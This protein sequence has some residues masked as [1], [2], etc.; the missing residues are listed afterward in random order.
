MGTDGPSRDV[1]GLEIGNAP[2]HIGAGEYV[3]VAELGVRG[4]RRAPNQ[5]VR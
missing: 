2:K 4:G 1:N 3:V 5:G